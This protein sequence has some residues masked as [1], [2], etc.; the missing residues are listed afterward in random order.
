MQE[1]NP[2]RTTVKII[3]NSLKRIGEIREGY[4]RKPLVVVVGTTAVGKSDFAMELADALTRKKLGHSED[5]H[6]SSSKIAE[7]ISADSLQV[8]KGLP[9]TTN[10]PTV[11]ELERIKHHCVANKRVT[12]VYNVKEWIGDVL[13]NG[14]EE[15]ELEYTNG[16]EHKSSILESIRSAGKIPIVVGGTSYYIETLLFANKM[17]PTERENTF[18]RDPSDSQP[19]SCHHLSLANYPLQILETVRNVLENTNGSL[20][21]AYIRNWVST[22]TLPKDFVH[23][24]TNIHHA[25]AGS[26]VQS[27]ILHELVQIIDPKMGKRW[28]PN[29]IRKCRRVVEVWY[30]TGKRISDVHDQQKQDATGAANMLRI[31]TILF[32]V[33]GEWE[34]V[35]DRMEKRVQKMEDRGLFRELEMLVDD[36][37]INGHEIVGYR[38]GT[39][40]ISQAIG[41]KEFKPYLDFYIECRKSMIAANV[42]LQ[43]HP[44]ECDMISEADKRAL[45]KLRLQGLEL[46]NIHTRQYAKRQITWLRNK[47]VHDCWCIQKDFMQTLTDEPVDIHSAIDISEDATRK[48]PCLVY[49]VDATSGRVQSDHVEKIADIVLQFEEVHNSESSRSSFMPFPGV[50]HFSPNDLHSYL[51]PNKNTQIWTQYV[52]DICSDADEGKKKVLNGEKEWVTHLNSVAHKRRIRNMAKRKTRVEQKSA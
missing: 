39:L 26:I 4:L 30:T 28:H 48:P 37:L 35:R 23:L 42:E 22:Q 41:F 32:W 51:T 44:L 25:P 34:R 15:S 47:L 5:W 17:I 10:Q 52:C 27:N 3:N 18:N 6:N 21:E 2:A 12:E 13:G 40:G 20:G 50:A 43:K 33:V 11:E 31:P 29:D 49:L 9:I 36:A 1:M 7:I 24:W 19:L 14:I 8:Y 46:M 16:N 45:R 38:D